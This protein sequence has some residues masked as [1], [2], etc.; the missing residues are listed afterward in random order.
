[1]VGGGVL[2]VGRESS[3]FLGSMSSFSK[4]NNN[5]SHSRVKCLPS[6]YEDLCF[7]H[8]TYI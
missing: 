7:L 3:K 4:P 1:M 8:T 6:K 2:G 5:K